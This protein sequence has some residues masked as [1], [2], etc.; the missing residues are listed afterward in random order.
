MAEDKKITLTWRDEAYGRISS[1]AIAFRAAFGEDFSEGEL[2]KVRK[3][4][5]DAGFELN[6]DRGS[7]I[8]QFKPSDTPEKL[9]EK[10]VALGVE[11]EHQGR[12]PETLEETISPLTP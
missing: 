11:V 1:D 3:A 4:F 9:V 10:L 5:K 6:F 7:W 2:K 12:V 8:A